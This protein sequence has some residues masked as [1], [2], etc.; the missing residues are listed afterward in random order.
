[1]VVLS[2]TIRCPSGY[3]F[4]LQF[5]KTNLAG[6]EHSAEVEQICDRTLPADVVGS[7]VPNASCVK[8][9]VSSFEI[10]CRQ[11][12]CTSTLYP[13]FRLTCA[14][15]SR[16]RFSFVPRVLIAVD[17]VFFEGEHVEGLR[18]LVLPPALVAETLCN[19]P[20]LKAHQKEYNRKT[21][22]KDFFFD[23]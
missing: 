5:T 20:K 1:M 10:T 9:L 16:G 11:R 2:S 7:T 4:R 21:H 18:F 8:G 19:S 12:S 3:M 6:G 15:G 17:S 23:R 22:R 13:V 14:E